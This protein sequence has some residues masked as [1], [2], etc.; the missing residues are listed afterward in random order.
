[1]QIYALTGKLVT[2]GRVIAFAP[3]MIAGY[4]VTNGFELKM[5]DKTGGDVDAFFA[6]VQN[7][8]AQLNAQ[9]EIQQAYTTF[10]PDIPPV[11]DRD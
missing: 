2:D 5:Q 11:Q 8:L 6:I 4:S 3:P 10:Q 7:F 9:P 1:M